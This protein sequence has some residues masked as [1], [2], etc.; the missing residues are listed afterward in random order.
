MAN[1][2]WLPGYDF[3]MLE[4]TFVYLVSFTQVLNG[5]VS[6]IANLA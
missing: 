5:I 4:T 2:L 3:S 1:G 6:E